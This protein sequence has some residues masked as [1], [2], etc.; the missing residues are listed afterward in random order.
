MPGFISGSNINNYQKAVFV[1][2]VSDETV[3]TLQGKKRPGQTSYGFV[4]PENLNPNIA[5]N[6]N[7]LQSTIQSQILNY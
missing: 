6:I 3:L 5:K 7:T 1:K 4:V 2:R